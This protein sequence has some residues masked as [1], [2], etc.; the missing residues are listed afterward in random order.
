[1]NVLARIFAL[2]ALAGCAGGIVPATRSTMAT[3]TQR[4]RYVYVSDRTRNRLLVYAL[5][6][7]VPLRSVGTGVVE[8]QGLALDRL[9]NV[10]L[11][12][13]AG[14]NILEFTAG[15]DRLIRS[16]GGVRAARNVAID[17]HGDL[18]V[19]DDR[20]LGAS[21]IVEFS[22]AGNAIGTLRTLFGDPP[23][24]L[25]INA[26]GDLF[27][28]V[29]GMKDRWPEPLDCLA[30]GEVDEYT[31]ARGAPHFTGANSEQPWGLTFDASGTLYIADVCLGTVW[32][33]AP[34]YDR[35]TGV[36]AS[37]LHN[38]IFLTG[39]G[40]T[41]VVPNADFVGTGFVDVVP[42]GANAAAPVVLNL[43]GLQGPISAAISP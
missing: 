41:L 22:P 33:A 32:A 3:S 28:S 15:A 19:G 2:L 4:T 7:P 35:V 29:T 9:G 11:A 21:R 26:A 16:I 10:Y 34:P 30:I 8:A 18:Y 40:E 17:A 38:P 12:N 24:G 31:H 42:I 25:A 37:G 1:M 13:G 5:G 14:G 27:A 6:N 20:G 39:S 36:V 43:Q 23:R